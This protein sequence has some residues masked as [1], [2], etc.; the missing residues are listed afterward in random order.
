MLGITS[1]VQFH[2]AFEPFHG[3]DAVT[4][5]ADVFALSS[6][7]EGAPVALLELAARG[8]PVVA[9]ATAGARWICGDNYAWLVP[10]GDTRRF[11]SALGNLLA[12]ATL[13]HAAG[14]QLRIRFQAHFLARHAASALRAAYA[15]TIP[16]ARRG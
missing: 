3:I 4:A 5:A 7:F 11:A 6:L 12:S 14:R 9:T 15:D 10:I 1:H 16:N 2:G 13:R 8:M